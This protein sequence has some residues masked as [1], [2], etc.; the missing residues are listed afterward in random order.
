MYHSEDH[1]GDYA[2]F[3]TNKTLNFTTTILEA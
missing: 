3:S 2:E 1:N